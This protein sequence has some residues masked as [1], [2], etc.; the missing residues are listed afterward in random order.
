MENP[1]NVRRLAAVAISEAAGS[2]LAD[3]KEKVSP[4]DDNKKWTKYT[5]EGT[6]LNAWNKVE[7]E[8]RVAAA[9]EFINNSTKEAN[10]DIEPELTPRTKLKLDIQKYL[11]KPRKPRKLPTLLEPE[12][13]ATDATQAG[14]STRTT[15]G[16]SQPAVGGIKRK[17]GRSMSSV[18]FPELHILKMQASASTSKAE[19]E[20]D[21]T[22]S[23]STKSKT[24]RSMNLVPSSLLGDGKSSRASASFPPPSLNEDK[25]SR[26]FGRSILQLFS[27][28]NKKKKKSSLGD[29]DKKNSQ[30]FSDKDTSMP[31]SPVQYFDK[32]TGSNKKRKSSGQSTTL[33]DDL[34][35]QELDDDDFYSNVEGAGNK[36]RGRTDM[37]YD[38]GGEEEGS[39]GKELDLNTKESSSEI[40]SP[41]KKNMWTLRMPMNLYASVLPSM[42]LTAESLAN[43]FRK[44]DKPLKTKDE[45]LNQG[46]GGVGT[47]TGVG[48]GLSGEEAKD[49]GN[50]KF[51]PHAGKKLTFE[52]KVILF[53][54]KL[55][56]KENLDKMAQ[57]WTKFAEKVRKDAKKQKNYFD[58]SLDLVDSS[59]NGE[60]LKVGA[61]LAG[62]ANP[63]LEVND[64]NLF[65]FV[66]GKIVF[67]DVQMGFLNDGDALGSE[68]SDLQRVC[69]MLV[70]FGGNVNFRGPD[71]MNALHLASASGDTRFI[72]F[73]CDKCSCDTNY[74]SRDG[75]TSIMYAAK[76]GH[77]LSMAPLVLAGGEIN[78]IDSDL[79]TP[80]H[81]AAMTGQTRCA[82]FLIRIGANKGAKD[83]DGLTPGRLADESGFRACAQAIYAFSRPKIKAEPRL[84]YMIEGIRE[85]TANKAA[86]R[87]VTSMLSGALRAGFSAMSDAF[88]SFSSFIS[89][90][91]SFLFG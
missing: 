11:I 10:E 52:E 28:S 17:A 84:Q 37:N 5:S 32:R 7:L 44:I 24:S 38:E 90:K 20:A 65:L 75:L 4:W 53:R 6:A 31:P 55:G 22:I 26:S 79:R 46:N 48:G 61:I 58:F 60:Y 2:T 91:F 30:I 76:Y 40:T 27:F 34:F 78:A 16:I 72:K 43:P 41:P 77:A 69:E 68:Q 13:L 56:G 3:K 1:E 51:D 71:G 59:S 23:Q 88:S 19:A 83:K 82:Q 18:L 50:S 63:N 62:G 89:D 49:E 25:K 86:S 21:M 80:L 66:A 14:V 29:E 85:K 39:K 74:R 47:I 8:Q 9:V 36:Q 57:E 33:T 15:V 87:P 42:P 67:L 35:V 81:Y 54:E 73:L 12:Q 45:I 70:K 64:L